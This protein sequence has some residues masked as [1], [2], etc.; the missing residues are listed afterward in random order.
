MLVIPSLA[1]CRGC[2]WVHVH[3]LKRASLVLPAVPGGSRHS[4][5]TPCCRWCLQVVA[6]RQ[7]VVTD[8]HCQCLWVVTDHRLALA[9]PL[10]PP[11]TPPPCAHCHLR[12]VAIPCPA[13]VVRAFHSFKHV[14]LQT[15]KGTDYRHRF[16]ISWVN[17]LMTKL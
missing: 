17:F 12:V 4:P 6:D 8:Q 3:P 14:F 11:L 10:P 7:W 5:P 9:S 1:T 16:L 13:H 15:E 2:T